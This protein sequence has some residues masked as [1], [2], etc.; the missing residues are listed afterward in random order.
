[1]AENN[2]FD[3][4]WDCIE[5]EDYAQAKEYFEKAAEE[6]VVEAYCELGNLYFAGNGVD[7]DYKRAFEL[8]QKG[9]KA[10]DPNSLHNLGMCYFWGQGTETDLQK[11]AFYNEKAAKAGVVKSMFDMGLNY[12]RGYGVS[13]NIEKALFWFEKAA[14]EDFPMAFVELGNLYFVGELVEKDLEKSF[15]YYKRGAELNNPTSKLQLSEFYEEGI[16]VEKDLE[17]A[18]SLCQEAYDYYYEK[19]IVEDDGEAQFR[20]GIIYFYGMPLIDIDKD[21]TQSA[22]WFE[23]SAKNGYDHAQN[24]LGI[25]YTHGIGVAQNYEKAFY[26]Y[27]QAAERMCQEAIGNVANCYYLGRGVVQD[28]DKA[29]EYHTKAANLGYANSQEVL[30][31]MYMDGKGVEQ[32]FTQAV[33]WLKQSCDNGE[34][35]AFGPLGD[36]YRK[37]LGVDKDEKKSFEL[38]QKGTEMGDLRSKVSMAECLIEGWGVK[39]DIQQATQ[40][41]EAICNDEVEYRDNLVTMTSREDEFGHIFMQNPLDEVNLPYYAKAYYLLGTLYYAGKGSDGG[42]TSKAIAMLRMADKLGYHNDDAPEET[43]EK[44]LNRIIDTSEKEEICDAVD[45]YVEIRERT[46]KGERYDVVLHHAD[47]TESVVKFKGRN[48]FIYILALLIA[49]E[50]KSVCGMTTTHFAY[51]REDLAKMA[52]TTR[53]NVHSY[54]DWIDEF[55]YAEK[56][57]AKDLR[58]EKDDETIGLCS[59]WPYRYSNAFSGANRAIKTC[60][61]SNDEYETFKMRSTGGRQSIITMALDYSQIEIPD[62]LEDYLDI[63]PTQ[64]EISGH[65]P[66]KNRKLPVRIDKEEKE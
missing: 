50:G 39:C 19:A 32:N 13:Q 22:E 2:W 21:Y 35:T 38:Y 30:G 8:Y 5:A 49:H 64:K 61:K 29:A 52:E 15:N 40:L 36:C 4:A 43:A 10:G 3:K 33:Y 62:S 28:Y 51:I 24:N 12:E 11:A 18:K 37:G 23:K 48:K 41:L 58:Y 53:I 65:V 42:D 17:K 66:E 20:L 1:M 55:L 57:E 31:G 7:K 54:L 63:L 56:D 44:I 26:W 45:C 60:C 47:G 14:E 59:L 6:G 27:S 25:M 46:D 9:A 16:I 34:M